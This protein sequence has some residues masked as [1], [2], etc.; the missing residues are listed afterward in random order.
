MNGRNG[1]IKLHRKMLDWG[2][3]HDSKV[4]DL[5]IHLLLT[6]NFKESKFEDMTI[7]PG[8]I[9]TSIEALARATKLSTKNVRTALE[10][11]E[12]SKILAKQSTSR[13]TLITIEN[14]ALYQ[15]D[16]IKT[17][18]ET[19]NEW[20]TNGK[21]TANERQ[22][23]KNAKN[24]KNEKNNNP[25]IVPPQGGQGEALKAGTAKATSKATWGEIEQLLDGFDDEFRECYKDYKA[26]RD[27]IKKP[28]TVRAVKIGLKKLNG[29]SGGD[30]NKAIQIMEQSIMNSWQDFFPLKR[31]G[32]T[33]ARVSV[34]DV[35]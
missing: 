30:G 16:E 11:M 26:M 22:H 29:L 31:K 6:A 4:K 35:L 5:F 7:Y 13:F 25:P 34:A 12:K 15:G 3:Y 19:A 8:Q 14:W 23:H 32:D 28:L 9:L 1:Y 18:N 21:R 27:S 24:V 20:Q 2:W 33:H 10:K 17:A